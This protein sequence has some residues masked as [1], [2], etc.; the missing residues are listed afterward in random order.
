MSVVQLEFA[1]SNS[2]LHTEQS[3]LDQ[4]N[5]PDALT[6]VAWILGSIIL[7]TYAMLIVYLAFAMFT[8]NRIALFFVVILGSF[9]CPFVLPAIIL[10]LLSTGTILERVDTISSSS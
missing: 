8:L 1:N 9:L 3:E 7:L 10:I 6:I 2:N 4:D 5:S